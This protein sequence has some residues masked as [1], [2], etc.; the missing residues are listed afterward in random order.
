MLNPL[1]PEET[2]IRKYPNSFI[3]DRKLYRIITTPI[4]QGWYHPNSIELFQI[5]LRAFLPQLISTKIPSPVYMNIS[6]DTQGPKSIELKYYSPTGPYKPVSLIVGKYVYKTSSR[7]RTYREI[8][9]ISNKAWRELKAIK[10]VIIECSSA[11]TTSRILN[12]IKQ[13]KLYESRLLPLIFQYLDVTSLIAENIYASTIHSE[14]L[15]LDDV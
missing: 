5:R 13:N 1:I 9:K 2:P 6:N 14:I 11:G 15:T 7:M 8:E 3:F 10:Y 4:I 12:N